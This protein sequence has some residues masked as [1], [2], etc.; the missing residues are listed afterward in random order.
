MVSRMQSCPLM[1]DAPTDLLALVAAALVRGD[2]LALTTGNGDPVTL[3]YVPGG[4]FRKRLAC[5]LLRI[6]PPGAHKE[7]VAFA[8]AEEA[9]VALIATCPPE[10]VRREVSRFD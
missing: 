3:T 8:T 5:Y 9:A 2:H 4:S 7:L 6:G 10:E 1:P